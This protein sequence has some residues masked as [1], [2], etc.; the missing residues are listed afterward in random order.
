MYVYMGC[1]ME[2]NKTE[3][4]FSPLPARTK[5]SNADMTACLPLQDCIVQTTRPPAYGQKFLPPRCSPAN[6]ATG[7]RPDN[8]APL[9]GSCP[10]ALAGSQTACMRTLLPC[11]SGSF[12][13][14]IQ[15]LC[16]HL[17]WQDTKLHAR[18]GCG[19][20]AVAGYQTAVAGYQTVVAGYQTVVQWQ[21]TKLQ[22]SGRIPNCSAVAGYQTACTRWLLPCCSGRIPNCMRAWLPCCSGRFS[23]CFIE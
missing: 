20:A 8:F 12:S 7:L 3:N 10:A 6:K 1:L 9:H 4:A 5:A 18:G 14:C 13:N 22:C 17:Q 16:S 19:P 11:C 15:A 2:F 21:D 23:T